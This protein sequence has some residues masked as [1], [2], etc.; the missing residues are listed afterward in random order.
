MKRKQFLNYLDHEE[1][2]GKKIAPR[3]IIKTLFKDGEEI[4]DGMKDLMVQDFKEPKIE[5]YIG[6]QMQDAINEILKPYFEKE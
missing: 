3:M 6:A 4:P 1:V 2:N 5:L